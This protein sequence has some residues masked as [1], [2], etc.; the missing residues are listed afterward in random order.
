M[1]L[2]NSI[3][4]GA[5]NDT[6]ESDE[7]EIVDRLVRMFEK[8]IKSAGIEDTFDR[9]DEEMALD[10]KYKVTLCSKGGRYCLLGQ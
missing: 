4:I 5:K 6:K 7:K 9:T 10:A 1:I 2:D 8:R 3:K